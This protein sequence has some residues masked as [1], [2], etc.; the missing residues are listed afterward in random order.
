MTSIVIT[1][2]LYRTIK[3]QKRSRKDNPYSCKW[4]FSTGRDGDIRQYN[5]LNCQC[6]NLISGDTPINE[7]FLYIYFM[8][9][10]IDIYRNYRRCTIYL[11][12]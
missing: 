7:V 12:R 1:D 3:D 11:Y 4:I 10:K 8:F 2:K 6:I 5:I 9:N